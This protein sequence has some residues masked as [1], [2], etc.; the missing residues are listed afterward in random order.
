MATPT[1]AAAGQVT[2]TVTPTV[3]AG[4]DPEETTSSTLSLIYIYSASTTAE[5]T[6]AASPS[7]KSSSI[8]GGAIAGI[9]VGSVAFLMI[10]A[11]ALFCC[12]RNLARKRRA[13]IASLHPSRNTAPSRAYSHATTA[14]G[15]SGTEMT[16]RSGGGGGGNSQ[17]ARSVGARSAAAASADKPSVVRVKSP[18][19]DFPT[20]GSPQE[21]PTLHNRPELDGS[22]G[23]ARLVYHQKKP[24]PGVSEVYGSNV[25]PA[26]LQAE[27]TTHLMEAIQQAKTSGRGR[28]R[29]RDTETGSDGYLSPIPG[30]RHGPA[31]SDAGGVSDLDGTTDAGDGPEMDYDNMTAEEKSIHI[32]YRPGSHWDAETSPLSKRQSQIMAAMSQASSTQGSRS[33]LRSNTTAAK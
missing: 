27:S 2:V 26:E 12:S 32:Y 15:Q 30:W 33:N 22:R 3:T 9:V 7:G 28:D 10:V 16:H 23:V 29:D 8:G 20:A 13:E 6:A 5:P 4:S 17:Y 24:R 31:T 18:K 11:F 1:G 14:V 25:Y 21:L 19:H